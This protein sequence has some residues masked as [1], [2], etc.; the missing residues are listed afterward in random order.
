V[1]GW[2]KIERKAHQV[3]KHACEGKRTVACGF[4]T[5]AWR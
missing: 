1:S 2:A 4:S 3:T 5:V